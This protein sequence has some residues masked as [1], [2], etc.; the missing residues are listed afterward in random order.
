MKKTFFTFILAGLAICSSIHA[1][2]KYELLTTTTCSTSSTPRETVLSRQIDGYID[3][4]VLYRTVTNGVTIEIGAKA[5][6][7]AG[8]NADRVILALTTV[9]TNSFYQ[10]RLQACYTG[11]G[12]LT[13]SFVK[14]PLVGNKIYLKA[15]NAVTSGLD[16]SAQI[17]YADQ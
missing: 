7:G 9:S 6:Q 16:I 17:I 15:Y 2:P 5:N 3:S 11:G 1:E 12:V 13:N 14:I 10:P 4:V 8:A